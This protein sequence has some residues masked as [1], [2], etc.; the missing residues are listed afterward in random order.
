MEEHVGWVTVL[1][2]TSRR[3]A[4]EARLVLEAS[5]IP[6]DLEDE[7]GAFAVL[8]PATRRADAMTQL[9][10]YAEESRA[11]PPRERPETRVA[12]HGAAAAAVYAA[13]ICAAWLLQ[14][15]AAF[16]VDWL[17]R[18]LADAGRIRAGEWWRTVTAL[19][20]HADPVHLAS[21]TVFGALFIAGVA[22]AIGGGA[23]LLAVLLA[24]A[25]GNGFNAWVQPVT[26]TSIGASTA[27]FGA[28][29]IL[30]AVLFRRREALRGRLRR[31]TPPFIALILLGYL[32]FSGERTDVMAHVLGTLAG[33]SLGLTLGAVEVERL[34][35]PRV[36]TGA[37]ALAAALLAAAWAIAAR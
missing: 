32:G 29:G 2:T 34:R 5:S 17:S 25:V 37:A 1:R 27:T 30:A 26:H 18:G 35:S 7:V 9:A 24:G 6:S 15:T 33:A 20:L 22:Q 21:N 28:V 36:Q 11:W 31:W 3:E 14:S 19:T 10:L 4:D 13:T 23:A 16:G 8:A 12:S